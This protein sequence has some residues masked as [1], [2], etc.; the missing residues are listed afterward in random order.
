M[1]KIYNIYF[2]PTGSSKGVNDKIIKAF[3]N[4]EKIDIDL[5]EN[6]IKN[7]EIEKGSICIISMPCYGGRIPKTALERLLHIRGNGSLAVVCISYGNRAYEDSLLELANECE[8]LNFKIIAG[9]SAVTEHNIMHVFGKGR[10]DK[11]DVEEIEKFAN[12]VLNKLDKKD[13]SKPNFKGNYTY[14]EWK[15]NIIPILFNEEKCGKC[16]LCVE[17]CP[18]NAISKENMQTDLDKCINCMRCIEICPKKCRKLPDNVLSMIIEK[19]KPV[20][21][22]RKENEFF[23]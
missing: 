13:Y 21:E 23:I 3:K 20:C 5:C 10:P 22:S 6:N 18:V 11:S 1:N 14:K 16:G 17:K 19:M 15:S 9:C 4:K 2:S 12:S 8:K 7:T